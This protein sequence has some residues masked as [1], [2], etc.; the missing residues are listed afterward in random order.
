MR[1]LLLY[2]AQQ[3]MDE[4]EIGMTLVEVLV[5]ILLLSIIVV[6]FLTFFVQ[7]K[8]TVTLSDDVSNASY[9]AQTEMENIYHLS[10]KL[11]F[12]QAMNQLKTEIPNYSEAMD[13]FN[14]TKHL[15]ANKV[16]IRISKA[17][18]SSG[19]IIAEELKQIVIYVYDYSNKLKAQ[20][21]TKL[22]WQ[23]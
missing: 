18:D 9:L 3:N 4:Q 10:E 7:S 16:N 11:T 2:K 12:D 15:E 1:P 23:G 8:K 13:T 17:E 21:E 5:S 19:T 14:F 6:T 22:L 20:V